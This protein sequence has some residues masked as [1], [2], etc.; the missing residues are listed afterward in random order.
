MEDKMITPNTGMI[1]NIFA[2]QSLLLITQ[3][4]PHIFHF[5]VEDLQPEQVCLGNWKD[6]GEMISYFISS[7]QTIIT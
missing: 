5:C 3:L 4:Q 1:A 7:I 6:K 2:S